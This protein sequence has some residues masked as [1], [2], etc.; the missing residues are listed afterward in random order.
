MKFGWN[1][2]VIDDCFRFKKYAKI[3]I[4]RKVF[5]ESIEWNQK[6]NQ[7][8]QLEFHPFDSGGEVSLML[9]L[10]SQGKVKSISCQLNIES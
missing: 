1:F 4:Y 8:E 3:P 2:G 10:L 9:E 7:Q 5:E 6:L